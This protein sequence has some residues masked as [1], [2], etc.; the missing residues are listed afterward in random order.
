MTKFV[1]N[2]FYLNTHLKNVKLGATGAFVF[3]NQFGRCMAALEKGGR[4]YGESCQKPLCV[5][6]S[7]CE[8]S[9]SHL[10]K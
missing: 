10:Q 7:I 5:K 3:K 2:A 8:S 6:K 9:L 1:T 4:G